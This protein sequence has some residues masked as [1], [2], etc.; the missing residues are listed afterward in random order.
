[1]L[2][3]TQLQFIITKKV[4]YILIWFLVDYALLKLFCFNE[5]SLFFDVEMSMM[6]YTLLLL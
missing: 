3:S 5:H 4:T 6:L 1:M 2:Y